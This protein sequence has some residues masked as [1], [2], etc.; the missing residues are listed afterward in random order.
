MSR[1][2]RSTAIGAL[3]DRAADP[4]G[5]ENCPLPPCIV[6]ARTPDRESQVRR[7][8]LVEGAGF[9]PSVPHQKGNAFRDSTVQLDPSQA[10]VPWDA[11]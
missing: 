6:G 8:S 11:I 5:A 10:G 7:R 1:P 9:E 2:V 3:Q 4:V